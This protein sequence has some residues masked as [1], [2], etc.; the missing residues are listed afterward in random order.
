[1]VEGIH[2]KN[3]KEYAEKNVERIAYIIACEVVK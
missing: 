2:K 3:L 1:M